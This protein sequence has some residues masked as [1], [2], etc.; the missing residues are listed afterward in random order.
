VSIEKVDKSKGPYIKMRMELGVFEP[1]P[2]TD[3]SDP[4]QII[5]L[6]KKQEEEQEA[7]VEKIV[8]TA[9]TTVATT[10]AGAAASTKTTKATVIAGNPD[11]GVDYEIKTIPTRPKRLDANIMTAGSQ[12]ITTSNSDKA[13]R[14]IR[15]SGEENDAEFEGEED[16][17]G[18]I[19]EEIDV[20]PDDEEDNSNLVPGVDFVPVTE[21]PG[22]KFTL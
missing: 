4:T 22:G 11:E 10:P 9:P 21:E 3:G 7:S 5:D 8:L 20:E 2:V 6:R 16:E 14:E 1:I 13:L 17:D 19:G 15:A 18:D 12:V